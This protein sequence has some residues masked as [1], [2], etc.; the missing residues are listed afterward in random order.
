MLQ[1]C[2]HAPE[3]QLLTPYS[4]SWAV[5]AVI[6]TYNDSAANDTKGRANKY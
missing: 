1:I 3:D 4:V 2:A 5:H 6:Y